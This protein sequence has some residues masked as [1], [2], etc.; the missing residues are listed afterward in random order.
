MK[1]HNWTI[2]ITQT[3]VDMK[4]S[5]CKTYVHT[6]DSEKELRKEFTEKTNCDVII[7]QNA[8]RRLE[9]LPIRTCLINYKSG[10]SERMYR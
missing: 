4:C 9:G 6:L 10:I 5:D 8:V 3:G 1:K 2:S 7:A